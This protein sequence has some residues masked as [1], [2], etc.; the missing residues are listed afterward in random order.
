MSK[1]RFAFLAIEETE[2]KRIVFIVVLLILG[3][4]SLSTAPT[5]NAMP[6]PQ[7]IGQVAGAK[8]GVQQ[9]HWWRHHYYGHHG[10]YYYRPYYYRHG[11]YHDD[12]Y[13][14]HR[15]WYGY[16]HKRCHDGWCRGGYYDD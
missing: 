15:H 11:Y 16:H 5:A 8:S 1:D 3:G 4:T 7:S 10:R 6:A 13:W 12:Y 14:K 9:A 2:M